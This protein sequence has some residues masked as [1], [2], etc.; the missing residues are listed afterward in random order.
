MHSI[1]R[2]AT[3]VLPRTQ[4]TLTRASQRTYLDWPL[5]KEEHVMIAQT[6][7]NYADTEL[8]HIAGKIDKE[9]KFPAEQV[10]KLGE[11][12]LMGIC[13]PSEFGGA[14]MDTLT[15]AI[16]MEEISRGCATTGVIMSANNSLFCYPVNAFGT[17]ELKE[18]FLT[19]V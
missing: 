10:K 18:K 2:I 8:K 12:G 6:C 3:R 7:R 9:H 19:P 14:D 15:Y 16:A 17:K 13:V 11:L 4:V 5:L 1:S